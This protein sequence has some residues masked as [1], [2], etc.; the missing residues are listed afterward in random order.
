MVKQMFVCDFAALNNLDLNNLCQL[1][2]LMKGSMRRIH[3]NNSEYRNAAT[4]VHCR[5]IFY[6]K[7]PSALCR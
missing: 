2:G 3:R 1:F 7:T 6:R 4:I 5:L